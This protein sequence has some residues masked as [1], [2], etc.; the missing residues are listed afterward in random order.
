MAARLPPGDPVRR[1]YA[2]ER[3][4]QQRQDAAITRPVQFGATNQVPRGAVGAQDPYG[5]NPGTAKGF[6][7]TDHQ[8]P[9]GFREVLFSV[10]GLTTLNQRSPRYLILGRD[11]Y[12]LEIY[13]GVTAPTAGFTVRVYFVLGTPTGPNNISRDI[14]F[15]PHASGSTFN[16]GEVFI[17]EELP[18][19]SSI[20]MQVIAGVGTDLVLQAMVR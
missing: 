13:A 11:Q 5:G 18:V 10:N 6:A 16:I 3:R 7:R 19:G 14:S 9:P 4:E 20:S 12:C 15:A 17:G 2:R 8:H 1:T